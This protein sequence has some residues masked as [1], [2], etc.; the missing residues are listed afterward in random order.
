MKK[1]EAVVTLARP[2]EIRSRTLARFTT[3]RR[4]ER[5]IAKREKRDPEGVHRGDYGIDASPRADAEYQ[6]L[7]GDRS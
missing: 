2:G 3:V 7:K 4:A 1:R 6:R 5:F